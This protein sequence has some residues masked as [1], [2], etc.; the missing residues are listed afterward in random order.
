MKLLHTYPFDVAYEAE[1]VATI[2]N[3]DGVHLG[4]RHLIQ[5]LKKEALRLG[6]P[7]LVILFEPQPMEY[8]QKKQ[9]PARLSSI[10][11]KLDHLKQCGV[12]WIYCIR[13]N[14]TL[15]K[16]SPVDFAM[17]HVFSRFKV[18]TL[19]VGE[20]FRFGYH[21]E[22]DVAL[23]RAL[24][25]EVGCKVIQ[26]PDFLIHNERVSSTK[27]RVA[28]QDGQLDLAAVYLGRSYSLC[29]RVVHG[30]KRGR[31][32]GIPTANIRLNRYSTPLQGVF[33]VMVRIAGIT[34]QGVAN[35]GIRPTIDGLKNTLE[36]HLLDFDAIIYG[37]R[38]KVFFLHKLRDEVK[39]TTVAHLIEQIYKDIEEAK[40]YFNKAQKMHVDF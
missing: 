35:C 12:D 24:G 16:M 23:L 31:Q 33:A 40:T 13:F 15:A 7:L 8:F 26:F 2:G 3:F 19:M 22:G 11:E 21:R 34:A 1:V 10:R 18:K 20:D 38:L 9:A 39:F 29:G 6:V 30:D 32:W 14:T 25:A 4:H 37:Q 28:L 36:I 27:I 5:S 17:L